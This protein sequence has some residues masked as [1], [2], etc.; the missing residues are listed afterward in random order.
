MFLL[1]GMYVGS[2]E[3][4]PIVFDSECSIA[5]IP[6]KD[7]FCGPITT[8]NRIMIRL[9]ANAQVVGEGLVEWV[10]RDDYGVK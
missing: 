5:V 9:G 7:D 8:V 4:I 10:F 2:R 1:L 6:C 3:K